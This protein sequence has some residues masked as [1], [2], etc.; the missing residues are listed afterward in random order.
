MYEVTYFSW[1]PWDEEV[2]LNVIGISRKPI[3]RPMTIRYRLLSV[4][5]MSPAYS[6]SVT[7]LGVDD[8]TGDAWRTSDVSKP[9]GDLDGIYGTDGYLIA[10][11]PN[12][13]AANLSQP[14]YGTIGL[15]RGGYEG[16]GAENHQSSF[17]DVLAAGPGP[18]ADLVAGDYWVNNNVHHSENDFFSIT[19]SQSGSFTL[20][21][22]A[23]Q[24]PDNPAG[25]LWESSDGVRVTGP[26]GI[27]SG[28]ADLVPTRDAVPDYVIFQIS[29][30]V[31]DEFTVWG[32]NNDGWNANALGGVFLDPI[33][34]PTAPLLG[35]LGCLGLF[36][37]RRR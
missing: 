25:L 29:G 6:A 27:D 13:N 12:G 8:G 18:V 37:R 28:M 36:L 3:L 4:A 30:D 7:L 20:G 31:G 32:R 1:Q 2:S 34:E 19:L 35:L 15:I 5:V 16:A 10:Q 14:A 11:Y 33:P 24:T 9:F 26:G 23:D 22:I 21:V 17:D